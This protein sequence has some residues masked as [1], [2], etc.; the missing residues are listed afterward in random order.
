MHNSMGTHGREPEETPE[1]AMGPQME[2]KTF[3]LLD[4]HRNL[5]RV[6][7]VQET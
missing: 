6:K 2:K 4:D 3:R 7:S 1:L 5:Q